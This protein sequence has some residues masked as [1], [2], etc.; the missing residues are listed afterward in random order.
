MYSLIKTNQF[1]PFLAK[2]SIL[3]TLKT[4]ALQLYEITLRHGCSPVNLLHIF[5]TSFPKITSGGLFLKVESQKTEM[6]V[7]GVKFM[8]SKFDLRVRSDDI[9]NKCSITISQYTS[10]SYKMN[11]N[12]TKKE[13][14]IVLRFAR[15]KSAYCKIYL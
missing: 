15:I 3:Y 14:I 2:I 4:V 10:Y 9:N 11:T 1:N 7:C 13:F 12:T 8:V 5:R 6:V